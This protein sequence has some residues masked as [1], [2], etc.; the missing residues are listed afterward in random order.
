MEYGVFRM[1]VVPNGPIESVAPARYVWSGDVEPGD[2][3]ARQRGLRRRGRRS[4]IVRYGTTGAGDGRYNKQKDRRC[5]CSWFEA[6]G[7]TRLE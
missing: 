7:V 4:R 2:N 6:I 5:S 3:Y 1:V